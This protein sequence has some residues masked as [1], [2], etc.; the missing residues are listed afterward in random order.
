MSKLPEVIQWKYGPVADCDWDNA[1][2]AWKIVRWRHPSI[3]QPSPAQLEA[4]AAEY[5]LRDKKNSLA[6]KRYAVE[7]AG[8]NFTYRTV[9]TPVSTSRE[10]RASMIGA[11][12]KAVEGRW[13]E[14]P[15]TEKPFKFGDG[16]FRVATTQEVINIYR[17]V[18]VHVD[19]CY[20]VEAQKMAEIDATGTTDLETGWPATS[21]T[22]TTIYF[23]K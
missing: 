18:E 16:V 8:I 13:V 20:A 17:A 22:P 6:A 23:G 10:T 7:V 19:A 9:P 3:Q 12:T 2:G 15:A 5:A 14:A 4:D 21:N 11:Y 1:L